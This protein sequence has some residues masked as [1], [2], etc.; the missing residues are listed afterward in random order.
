M[1]N[2]FPDNAQGS[3]PGA[4]IETVNKKTGELIEKPLYVFKAG[5]TGE[6]M[7]MDD[8][9]IGHDGFTV[10]SNCKT[11]KTAMTVEN[12]RVEEVSH[13]MEKFGPALQQIKTVSMD[14]SATYAMVFNGLV[15]Q[16]T[17]AADKFHVMKYVYEAVRKVGTGTVKELQHQLTKGKKRTEEDKK[18]LREIEL[19]RRVSHAVTQ[20]PEKWNKEMQ[21]TVN[22]VFMKYEDL[23]MAYQTNQNFKRWYDYQN[24]TKST[25]QIRDN[26]YRWYKQASQIKEFERLIKMIQKHETQ[27][28]N[29]FRQGLTNAKAENL[30]GKTQRFV[31]NNYGIKDRDFFL[32]RTANYF[33]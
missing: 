30:N 27:I 26:L 13:A 17:Q 22:H 20:S 5:N 1:S 7:S 24:C 28:I 19:L 18:R 31:S 21:E 9:A 2:Y 16:A 32:Y 29:F 23:K 15:P 10:L 12:T 14:M 11:G 33:S 3:W 8:K 25:G 6:Q 4:A